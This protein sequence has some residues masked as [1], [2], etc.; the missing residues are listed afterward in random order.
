[1]GGASRSTARAR[2]AETSFG[3]AVP[4]LES[5]Q[6]T[7]RRPAHDAVDWKPGVSLELTQPGARGVPEDAVDPPGIEA[8]RAQALLQ[9]R[10]VVAAE[11]GGAPVQEPVPEAE[12][13]LHQGVPRLPPA[14]TVDP[15]AT[16]ALERFD[17]GPGGRAEDPVGIDGYARKD[18]SEA[19][20]DVGHRVAAMSDRQRERYRYA[21]ISSTSRPFGFAPI[22]RT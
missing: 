19:M 20:L 18:A 12:S 9:F 7:K 21:E 11:H 8:E 10:H 1:M 17:R 22:T 4:A 15:Q 2:T 16:E 3:I 5:E 6:L 14:D 13:R